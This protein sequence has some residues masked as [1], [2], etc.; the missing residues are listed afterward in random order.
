MDQGALDRG[1]LPL[2]WFGFNSIV[3]VLFSVLFFPTRCLQHIYHKQM[4]IMDKAGLLQE[5]A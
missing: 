4:A 3:T 2:V 5:K 1:S